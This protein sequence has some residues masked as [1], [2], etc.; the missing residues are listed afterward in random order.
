[1]DIKYFFFIHCI[2]YKIQIAIGYD[3]VQIYTYKYIFLLLYYTF[4]LYVCILYMFVY[5][6]FYLSINVNIFLI[7]LFN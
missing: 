7:Y 1:M 2:I 6:M 4:I 3:K 5:Y